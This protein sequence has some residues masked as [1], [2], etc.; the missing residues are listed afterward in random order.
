MNEGEV[1][2]TAFAGTRRIGSGPLAELAQPVLSVLD[3]HEQEPILIFHDGTGQRLGLG[4]NASE[5]FL[6]LADSA[7]AR[8]FQ[9]EPGPLTVCAAHRFLLELPRTHVRRQEAIDAF[10]A[11]NWNELGRISLSWSVDLHN[12]L[13][14]FLEDFLPPVSRHRRVDPHQSPARNLAAIGAP[15]SAC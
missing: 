8:R 13:G 2:Y 5:L 1:T 7:L 3:G 15:W 11:K 6:C 10:H 4:D 12:Y 14:K 9:E